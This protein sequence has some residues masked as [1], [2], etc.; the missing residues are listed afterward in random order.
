VSSLAANPRLL[1]AYRALQMTLFPVS[2]VTLFFRHRIGMSM[3]EILAVQAFFGLVVA[4]CEF[5][6]GYIADRIGYRRT[7]IAAAGLGALGWAVYATADSLAVIVVAQA[8]LGVSIALGSGCDSA[9]MYESLLA[10]GDEDSF[11]RWNGRVRFW[12]QTAEGTAALVAGVMYVAWPRLPFVA[13]VG[14]WLA[15]LGVALALVEPARRLSPAGAHWQQIKAMVRHTFVDDRHLTAVV[16]LTI[17]LGMASFVPVWLV[18]LYATDAG[19]PEAWIGPIW[20]LANYNVALA[21]L[22][23]DRVARVAGLMPTLAACVILVALGFGGLG[24]SYGVLGF[25]WYFALTT[26]RGLFGPALHHVENRLIPSSD[27]AGY[28]SLRSLVFRTLFLALGPAVGAAVDAHGQHPV[29]LA[30]GAALGAICAGLWLW[31][32]QYQRRAQPSGCTR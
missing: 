23:S 29:L 16:A 18:P 9:L 8:V 2:I 22:A 24:F 11:A 21:S 32:C 10:T 7:L 17:A 3:T 15:N 20:A 30:L 4:V 28:L 13:Q 26:M 6:S 1:C 27:R 25:A 14:V 5:P 19:V 12:G 31:L